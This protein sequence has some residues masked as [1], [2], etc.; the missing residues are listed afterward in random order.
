MGIGWRYCSVMLIPLGILAAS[1]AGGGGSFESIASATG[2]GS[3]STITFNSFPSTY[4]A[5]QLRLMVKSTTTAFPMTQM[6]ITFNS[7]TGSN[8][9]YHR[10]QGFGSGTPGSYGASSQSAVILDGIALTSYSGIN[11]SNFSAGIVDIYDYASTTRNKTVRA[12]SGADRNGAAVDDPAIALNSSVWLNTSAIT[13]IDVLINGGNFA[14][15][16]VVS[17]YGIKGA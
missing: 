1:G 14:S 9:S 4:A 17:L 3:N 15:N 13:S 12:F 8:Y 5:L 7:D 10:L 6:R 16:S 11:S 2:T